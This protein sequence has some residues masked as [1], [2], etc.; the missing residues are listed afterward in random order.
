VRGVGRTGAWPGGAR[1]Q[2]KEGEE[3]RR[4]KKEGKGK[5]GKEKEKEKKREGERKE[6]EEKEKEKEKWWKEKKKKKGRKGEKGVTRVGDIRGGN[7]DWS[8]TRARCSH[9]LREKGEVTVVGF[10]CRFGVPGN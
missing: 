8:A 4:R 7:R 6:N 2:R 1:E 9:A 10:G 5:G 3:G